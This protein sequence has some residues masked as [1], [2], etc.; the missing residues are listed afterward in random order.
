MTPPADRDMVGSQ[1]VR[2]RESRCRM[3]EEFARKDMN[4]RIDGA[5]RLRARPER[6]FC[7][8]PMGD[9]AEEHEATTRGRKLPLSRTMGRS[10]CCSSS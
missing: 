3:Q 6:G 4:D 9:A 7:L 2:N 8:R 10:M 5:G 1:Y